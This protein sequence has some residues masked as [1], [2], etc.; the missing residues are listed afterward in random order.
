MSFLAFWQNISSFYTS[1][2]FNYF[3][4]NLLHFPILLYYNK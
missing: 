3:A 4:Q 2:F 1:P